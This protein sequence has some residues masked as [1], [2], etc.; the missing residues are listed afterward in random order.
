MGSVIDFVIG[1]A[2]MFALVALVCAGLQE[3]LS[4]ALNLRGK[5][6]WEGVESMLHVN[7][8]N[9]ADTLMQLGDPPNIQAS[10]GGVTDAGRLVEIEM[11]KHPLIITLVPDRFTP[12]DFL[13]WLRGNREPK[14]GVGTAKPSYMQ[15]GTFATVLADAIG[16]IWKGGSRRFDDFP[17]AV[18]AMPSGNLQQ[19]LQGFIQDTRGDPERL[20]AAVEAWFDETMQRVSGWYKRRAQLL[21]LVI[22]FVVAAG[23]NVDSIWI[24]Q[25]LW[26][27]PPLRTAVADQAVATVQQHKELSPSESGAALGNLPIGWP[28][29]IVVTEDAVR[30]GGALALM[31]L[32]WLITGFGSAFGAPFWF[33]LIGKLVPLRSAGA[34]PPADPKQPALEEGQ[35]S[36]SGAP[37]SGVVPAPPGP[38]GP[39]G[40]PG[41]LPSGPAEA[42]R[43]ALNEY[44]AHSITP[45]QIRD[46]KRLLGINGVAATSAVLDQ[47]MRNAIRARQAQYRWPPSGELSAQWVEALRTGRA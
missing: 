28:G 8:S 9:N 34:K 40:P 47:T 4:A 1:M 12:A 37:A 42:F 43:A 29:R 32:G 24:A 23:L 46:V 27:Q 7:A 39:P 10:R 41:P 17:Q 5:T 26:T 38:S 14:P 31:F 22:G 16:K 30:K 20:R 18:A 13:A 33:D 6:L 35:V 11:R 15:A 36:Q 25:Q 45:D 19:I 2:F 3:M 21:L 44:E